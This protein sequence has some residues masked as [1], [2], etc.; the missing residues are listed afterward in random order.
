MAVFRPST[1]F[2]YQLESVLFQRD[3][4]VDL[5]I[6]LDS[7]ESLHLVQRYLALFQHQVI[8]KEINIE[9]VGGPMMGTAAGNFFSLV[10]RVNPQHD[11]YA[12]CD[13][14]DVWMPHKLS[15]AVRAM[16][17]N[18]CDCYSSELLVWKSDT[19]RSAAPV[20]RR[21][22][23]KKMIN[24]KFFF[25]ESAGCTYVLNSNAFTSLRTRLRVLSNAG[26]LSKV[27][28]HDLFAS[29]F[30]HAQGFNW[31]HDTSSYIYYR[32]HAENQWGASKFT[33]SGIM[34]RISRLSSGDYLVLLMMAWAGCDRSCP[35][36]P[37][38]NR[39]SSFK[40]FD[41]LHLLYFAFSSASVTDP[42]LLGLLYAIIFASSATL[43]SLHAI[44]CEVIP[45]L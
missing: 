45:N 13:Q 36:M 30:L 5:I 8:S 17:C 6:S 21:W 2:S 32:Q 42:R 18:R 25:A 7:S 41:R 26:T 15:S 14:D 19:S 35:V 29:V 34:K 11:F 38:L 10:T 33:I 3:V 9:I 28:S 31:W 37:A 44:R 40:F 43:Q 4:N 20:T 27:F 23:Q 16:T 39:L 22:L 1:Y 12:F 24:F